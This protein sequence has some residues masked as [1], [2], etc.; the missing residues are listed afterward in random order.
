MHYVPTV[1]RHAGGGTP[2]DIQSRRLRRLR[3]CAS[4]P[5]V[6]PVALP[7]LVALKS[8]SVECC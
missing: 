4:A 5:A 2:A 1:C 7:G 8:R 3:G 6:D